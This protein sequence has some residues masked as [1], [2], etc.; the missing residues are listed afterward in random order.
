MTKEEIYHYALTKRLEWVED[1]TNATSVYLRNRV[2]FHV[3]K[4]I[5][6]EVRQKLLK[7]WQRQI[8][9]KKMIET[10]VNTL[11]TTNS[12]YSRYFFIMT[13]SD[14]A[15]E[16]LRTVIW[17][18][19]RKNLLAAQLQRGVLAIK[20]ARAGTYIQ[21]GEG[22]ELHFNVTSFIALDHQKML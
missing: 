1:S 18:R 11:L 6:L 15:A 12:E 19:T 4:T 5:S 7:L 3:H 2:R 21:L 14:V 16:L 9:L 22:V 17:R 13:S 8:F 10:E 20:T